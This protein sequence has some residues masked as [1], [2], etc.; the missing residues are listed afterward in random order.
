MFVQPVEAFCLAFV[1]EV[2]GRVCMCVYVCVCVCMLS[3]RPVE[4]LY[5][6]MYVCMY[7]CNTHVYILYCLYAHVYHVCM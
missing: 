7:V 6:C 2:S 1:G 3:G 4:D 5:V